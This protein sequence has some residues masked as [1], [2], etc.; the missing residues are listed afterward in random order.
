MNVK[1][2]DRVKHTR[3]ILIVFDCDGNDGTYWNE[4]DM[5]DIK[6]DKPL[7]DFC[8]ELQ[9]KINGTPDPGFSRKIAAAHVVSISYFPNNIG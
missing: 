5:Y 7:N 8:N 3:K 2:G 6:H 1:K 4:V 9:I